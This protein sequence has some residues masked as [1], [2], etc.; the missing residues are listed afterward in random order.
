MRSRLNYFTS[1]LKIPNRVRVFRSWKDYRWLKQSSVDERVINSRS[2]SNSRTFG[3]LLN[4]NSRQ[5]KWINQETT[6]SCDVIFR[7]KTKAKRQVDSSSSWTYFWLSS[8]FPQIFRGTDTEQGRLEWPKN[9]SEQ[10]KVWQG[11]THAGKNLLM[12]TERPLIVSSCAASPAAPGGWT[13]F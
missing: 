11:A 3:L 12:R 1:D 13:L 6:A 5:F 8:T 10:G 2:P 4:L 7:A 9:Q